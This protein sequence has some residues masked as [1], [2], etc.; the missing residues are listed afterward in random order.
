M[1]PDPQLAAPE[2][3]LD[4][5]YYLELVWRSR[6]LIVATGLLGLFLGAV[7]GF[8]QTPEYRAG[9]MIQIDPPTPAF[10]SVQEAALLA[11]GAYWQNAD[12]YNTQ[13]K[14]LRSS[15][16]GAK[17]VERLKLKDSAPFKGS[18]ETGAL[19]N[20]PRDAVYRLGPADEVVVL[21][22]YASLPHS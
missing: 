11:G 9:A 19:L 14:V 16:L 6:K 21:T 22:T 5:R 8:L 2:R 7:V 3:D 4:V 18:S 10:L 12:Y 17:V 20:P 15:S 13:F 1:T